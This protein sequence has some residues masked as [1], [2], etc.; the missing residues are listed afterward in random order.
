MTKV[1]TDITMSLDGYVAG[2]NVRVEEPLGDGGEGLHE[3][4][5]GLASWQEMQRQSGGET[6]PEDDMVRATRART[7][8]TIMGRRMF[9]PA[10]GDWGDDPDRGPWGDNPPYHHPVFVLTH[11]ARPPLPM[12][13]GTT[14]H[15]LTDGIESALE[16]A[17]AAADDKDVHVAGGAEAVQQFIRNGLLDEIRVHIVPVLFGEGRRLF[18]HLGT[19]RIGLERVDV[20]DSP[21]ATHVGYRFVR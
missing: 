10:S 2:P 9:H 5:F 3:W 8:A 11:H 20:I 21:A 7:G 16:Q 1:F 14:F 18:D 19:G 13:G 4:M 12:K 17:K 6:G 15:F